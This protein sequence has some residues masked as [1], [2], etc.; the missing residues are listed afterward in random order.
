MIFRSRDEGDFYLTEMMPLAREINRAIL[1]QTNQIFYPFVKARADVSVG[2]ALALRNPRYGEVSQ[3][4]RAL[5]EARSD[6]ELNDRRALR[7]EKRTLIKVL[8]SGRIRAVYEPIV[9]AKNL[10]VF[11]YEALSR[12]PEG[13]PLNSP[14]ELFGL[15]ER[16]DLVFDLDCHCR[17]S[18]LEGAVDFPAGTKLFLNVRPSAFHDPSFQPD[19]LC[20]TLERCRLAPADVVFE[21]SEQES[22]E[23]FSIFRRARDDYGAIGFQFALD[24]T[25]SGYAS[26]QS[27]MEL[28][29]EFIKVDRAFVTG[30]DGDPGRQAI[31]HG[32]QTIADR[33][34]ARIVGEGLDTLEELATLRD[35]GIQFGQ[36]WLFGK[37]T[38]LRA[39]G[40]KS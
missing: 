14:L 20:R 21:I 4:R 29:P 8:L 5:D 38:P 11:A 35:L 34:D 17:K 25:G 23:N 19:E 33:I 39:E 16:T 18:A 32:F 26:F 7:S 9:D 12:G 15:A 10:T 6:A 27:V 22:I 30:I 40:S 13:T 3:V 28:S 1:R 31:L 36:G 24:D 37:P 2:M